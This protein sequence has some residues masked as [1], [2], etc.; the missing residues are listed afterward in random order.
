MKEKLVSAVLQRSASPEAV[1]WDTVKTMLANDHLRSRPWTRETVDRMNMEKSLAVYRDRFSNA[2]DF[3]FVFT[4]NFKLDEIKPLILTYIASLPDSGKRETVKDLGMSPAPGQLKKQVILGKDPKSMVM[5][6][7]HGGFSWTLQQVAVL[8]AITEIMNIRL[9][10]A[11]RENSSGAYTIQAWDHPKRV[12]RQELTFNIFFG[13]EPGRV[14]ELTTLVVREIELLAAKGI[15]DQELAKVKEILAKEREVDLTDN[16]IWAE[17]IKNYR[18]YSEPFDKITQLQE[19]YAK[20][21]KT[22]I[23]TAV[24]KYLNDDNFKLLSLYPEGFK[25]GN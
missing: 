9:T 1:F 25:P 10:D 21:T 24:K 6:V 19:E 13:C 22:D 4:G 23:Q 16:S 2:G 17:L 5:L 12:P 7:Y 14:N 15:T 20:L 18:I 8:K 3:T 11:V